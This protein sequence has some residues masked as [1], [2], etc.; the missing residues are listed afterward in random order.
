MVLFSLILLLL[1][2][3]QRRW[4]VS[5]R[6]RVCVCLSLYVD[7]WH[8]LCLHQYKSTH[9]VQNTKQQNQCLWYHCRTEVH[10]CQRVYVHSEHVHDRRVTAIWITVYEYAYVCTCVRIRIQ[11]LN[12]THT[13]MP[14]ERRTRKKKKTATSSDDRARESSISL[15]HFGANQHLFFPSSYAR[16]LVFR[17]FL[18][19]TPDESHRFGSLCAAK[20]VFICYFLLLLLF[21]VHRTR[22]G[23]PRIRVCLH[24]S[25]VSMCSCKTRCASLHNS[26][27]KLYRSSSLS[28]SLS[29]F[30][31]GCRS[32]DIMFAIQSYDYNPSIIA[33]CNLLRWV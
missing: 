6:A 26:F 17:L 29:F 25:G 11:C 22:I 27:S 28:L 13:H 15:A 23:V 7:I 31:S 20:F 16:F 8:S 14:N 12:T 5:A 19:L 1:L 24:V 33:S 18:L 3:Q 4:I 30:L 21:C 2:W 10:V 32:V 9:T